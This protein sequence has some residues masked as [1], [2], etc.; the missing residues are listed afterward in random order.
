MLVYYY[1]SLE[2]SVLFEY[3]YLIVVWFLGWGGEESGDLYQE[4]ETEGK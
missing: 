3:A 4:D 2:N 1:S